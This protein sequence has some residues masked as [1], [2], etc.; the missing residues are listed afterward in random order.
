MTWEYKIVY[1]SCE[2]LHDEERYESRLHDGVQILNELGGEGWELV[3]FFEHQVSK[4]MKK[5]HAV[6]KRPHAG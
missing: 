2:P 4:E 1:F 3:H 5:H 6:F